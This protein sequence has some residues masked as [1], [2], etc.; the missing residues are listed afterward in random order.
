MLKLLMYDNETTLLKE[1]RL[2]ERELSLNLMYSLLECDLVEYASLTK[3]IDI[4]VDEE[5]FL[6]NAIDVNIVYDYKQDRVVNLT[7]KMLFVGHDKGKTV[8]L[9]TEQIE[10]I[11]SN[12][13]CDTLP[14]ELFKLISKK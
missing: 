4:I 2:N 1:L 9:S 10:Y 5:G 13:M 7:G 12:I 8:S 11:K 14:L 3:D 6:K